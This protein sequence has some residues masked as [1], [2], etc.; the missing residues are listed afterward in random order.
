M[1]QGSYANPSVSSLSYDQSNQSNS[2][3]SKI[4]PPVIL[5]PM[6]KKTLPFSFRNAKRLCRFCL[7]RQKHWWNYFAFIQAY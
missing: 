1:S 3:N 7:M 2:P 6:V 4:T 5:P